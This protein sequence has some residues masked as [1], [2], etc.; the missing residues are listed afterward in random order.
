VLNNRAVDY[1]IR[2]AVAQ[3]S[4]LVSSVVCRCT[5]E[6]PVVVNMLACSPENPQADPR[7]VYIHPRPP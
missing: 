2:A 3:R 4:G 7:P 1:N 5:T 6:L